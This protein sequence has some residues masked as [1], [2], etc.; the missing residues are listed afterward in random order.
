MVTNGYQWSLIHGTTGT[1]STVPSPTDGC[2]T[3]RPEPPS[4]NPMR[5]YRQMQALL[6]SV[7]STCTHPGIRNV[8]VR[9][10]PCMYKVRRVLLPQSGP[11]I[12]ARARLS[13]PLAHALV[14]PAVS[15]LSPKAPK[16]EA[17]GG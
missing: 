16:Q 12:I 6:Q 3:T 7:S 4:G 1:A 13:E 17:W 10:R 8:N 15:V 5:R 11:A 14:L 2:L 9:T